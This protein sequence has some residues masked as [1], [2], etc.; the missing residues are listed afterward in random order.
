VP[1]SD[2]VAG[3]L[4]RCGRGELLRS[5]GSHCRAWLICVESGSED[6]GGESGRDLPVWRWRLPNST[7]L[8]FW[9]SGRLISTG[10]SVFL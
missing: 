5:G 7:C 3:P 8:N 9:Y 1:G 2:A 4:R 6:L 10:V